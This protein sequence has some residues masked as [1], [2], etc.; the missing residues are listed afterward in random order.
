ML[1]L[2][3]IEMIL[4]VLTP[5]EVLF[6]GNVTQVILPGLDGSFGI[7]NSH[8]PLI[9]A[10]SKG[11]VKVDQITAE[12]KSFKGRLNI[13]NKVNNS[14]T[15]NINGGVVEVNDNKILVLAE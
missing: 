10:L 7:L 2:N 3:F 4:E 9:S 5:D 11:A 12:N 1:T 6:E 13:E 8:A 14:F 15:F